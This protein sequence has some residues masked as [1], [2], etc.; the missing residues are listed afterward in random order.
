MTK[1]TYFVCVGPEN[2]ES[3]KTYHTD[4]CNLCLDSINNFTEYD[5]KLLVLSD[6]PDE[7]TGKCDIIEVS[8]E[9]ITTTQEV[10]LLRHKLREYIKPE[11]FES[12]L[13]L[14]NDILALDDITA[15]HDYTLDCEERITFAEEFPYNTFKTNTHLVSKRKRV[16]YEHRP[17]VNTGTFCID[18]RNTNKYIKLESIMEKFIREYSTKNV[19]QGINQL[20]V[21]ICIMNNKLTYSSIPHQWVEFPIPAL[22]RDEGI[23]NLDT[24]KF[25]HFSSGAMSVESQFEYMKTAHRVLNNT[26]KK[27]LEE[28]LAKVERNKNAKWLERQDNTQ[29]NHKIIQANDCCAKIYVETED[30]KNRL[31][32]LSGESE[33]LTYLLEDIT[34]NSVFYDIGANIGT[35]SLLIG[36]GYPDI[37][38]IA[39]EPVEENYNKLCKNIE[40]SQAG[41]VNAIQ[42]A[43]FNESKTVTMNKTGQK[44]GEGKHHVSESGETKIETVTATELTELPEPDYIKIDVEGA[45]YKALLGLTE[46]LHSL[47][48]LYIEV[49][50]DRM[51]K[52]YNDNEENMIEYLAEMG[53]SVQLLDERSKEYFIK[54][55]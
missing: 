53:Y 29:S 10:V 51:S 6:S 22:A 46:F 52:R 30:E 12:I 48:V 18:T 27:L 2:G 40:L 25:I 34:D 26:N 47:P 15:I 39:F 45:E 20:P 36:C 43:V 54:A 19:Y 21:Q 49:H 23:I 32:H 17:R 13:Y 16:E 38:V 11:T 8:Q 28:Q 42:K 31:R 50:P 7:I 3:A 33:F 24:V 55:V 9:E 35:H 1:L 4:M 5:D 37:D 14:D 44:A 41:N